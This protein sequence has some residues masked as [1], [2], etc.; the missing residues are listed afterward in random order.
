MTRDNLKGSVL[1][2]S[3]VIL[4]SDSLLISIFLWIFRRIT[5]FQTSIFQYQNQK[6]P[7]NLKPSIFPHI[8]FLCTGACPLA[9]WKGF[10]WIW[11]L[12]VALLLSKILEVESI[13]YSFHYRTCRANLYLYLVLIGKFFM[14]LIH[15]ERLLLW[16]FL[17]A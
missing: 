5:L 11:F 13:R 14:K 15:H 3:V 2:N 4:K 10:M 8:P 16:E 6:N 7:R 12:T 17:K 9:M 1:F